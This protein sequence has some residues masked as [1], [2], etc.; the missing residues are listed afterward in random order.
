MCDFPARQLVAEMK[1]VAHEADESNSHATVLYACAFVK[2]VNDLRFAHEDLD[3]CQCWYK[4]LREHNH[5]AE[6]V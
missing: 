2:A 4:A 6:T 1:R 5:I 3:E